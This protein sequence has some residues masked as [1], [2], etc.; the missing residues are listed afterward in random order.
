MQR[1]GS[2]R[3]RKARRIYGDDGWRTFGRRGS[4][5]LSQF[6][7]KHRVDLDHPHPTENLLVPWTRPA[8][9]VRRAILMPSSAIDQSRRMEGVERDRLILAIATARSWLQ[10]LVRGAIR[11]VAEL[12]A[13]HNRTLRSID[14]VAGVPRPDA[15]RRRLRRDPPTRLRRNTNSWISRHASPINGAPSV[16]SGPSENFAY[17]A[18]ARRSRP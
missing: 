15:D 14:A 13:R 7:I 18:A 8:S 1:R 10:G 3:S 5:P 11:D 6:A 9:R 17:L 4:L 16:C 12:A 2:W